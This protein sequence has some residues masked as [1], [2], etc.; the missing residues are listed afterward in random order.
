MCNI[1]VAILFLMLISVTTIA[2]EGELDDLIT[3]LSSWW[4]QDLLS[5]CLLYKLN[6]KWFEKLS[7]ILQPGESS[8]W[9]GVK[10]EKFLLNLLTVSTK[11]L[12]I[13][14]C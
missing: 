5:F 7:I 10:E 12:L 14:D 6:M 2:V 11:W 1:D 4:A 8:E 3:M 13:R 9:R